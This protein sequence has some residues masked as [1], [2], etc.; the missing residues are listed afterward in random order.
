MQLFRSLID[1]QFNNSKVGL[2]IVF[3]LLPF[4]F[5]FAVWMV[6]GIAVNYAGFF[7]SIVRELVYWGLAT[8]LLFILLMAF[9]G[10]EVKGKFSSIMAAFSITYLINFLAAILTMI[11]IFISIP[12]FFSKISSLQGRTLTFE[13]LVS[14]VSSLALPSV[15]IQIMIFVVLLVIGLV[16]LLS[17]LHVFYRIGNL[18]KKTSG[19]SNLLF[20]VVFLGLAF[21]LNSALNY[22]FSFI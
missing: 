16:A 1:S 18:V 14:V 3:F 6:F 10:K 8:L 21:L 7:I 22:L 9:K 2:G 20:L 17:G 12:G 13:Q 5:I 19:F 4:I 15:E 11:V